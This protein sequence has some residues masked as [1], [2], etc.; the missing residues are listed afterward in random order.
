M[1]VNLMADDDW[2]P[3][4][5]T[6]PTVEHPL[7]REEFDALFVQDVRS[8]VRESPGRVCLELRTEPDAAARAAGLAVQETGCCSFFTF[9]LVISDGS[10]SLAIATAPTHEAVLTALAARAEAAIGVGE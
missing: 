8:V 10:V 2:A 3:E 7:R 4:A 5:C 6:L 9:E 1:S